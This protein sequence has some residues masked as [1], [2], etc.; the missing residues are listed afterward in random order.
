M[1][2]SLLLSSLAVV[3]ALTALSD[4]AD[5]QLVDTTVPEPIFIKSPFVT[6]QSILRF[7]DYIARKEFELQRKAEIP[8]EF[9]DAA[10]HIT[11]WGYRFERSIDGR[12][13]IIFEQKYNAASLRDSILNY[14]N[15]LGSSGCS[16]YYPRNA[17]ITLLSNKR[18]RA[19]AQLSGEKRACDDILGKHWMADIGGTASVDVTYRVDAT[20]GSPTDRFRGSLVANR[21]VV[22]IDLSATT[23]FGIKLD[24]E[25]LKVLDFLGK[26]WIANLLL[27]QQPAMGVSAP[28]FNGVNVLDAKFW[29]SPD[30]DF[31]APLYAKL[32][33]GN[34]AARAYSRFLADWSGYVWS[35]RSFFAMDDQLTGLSGDSTSPVLTVAY[36]ATA[37]K[38]VPESRIIESFRLE[39]DLLESFGAEPKVHIIRGGENL[40]EISRNHY[41]NPYL[42]G[43][44]GAAN[45]LFG[46]RTDLIRIGT[47]VTLLPLHQL[48]VLLDVWL[49][50]PGDTISQL[51]KER[52]ARLPPSDC[53]RDV[54]RLNKGR[55]ISK[56]RAFDSVRAPNLLPE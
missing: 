45:N 42:H 15:S 44:L 5:A 2:R 23:V 37:V 14:I 29:R 41:S 36:R 28:V 38:G 48:D 22:D 13:Q 40:W 50:R 9:Y 12:L 25:T 33:D 4:N 3:S 39:R 19:D 16:Y 18:I 7:K 46:E 26:A 6:E 35:T 53:I 49:L 52:R 32:M 21:P 8:V 1:N 51:C 24:E 27:F 10:P 17:R 43:L 30:L 11:Y 34:V 31:A 20:G 55:D 56:L 47:P 54:Q